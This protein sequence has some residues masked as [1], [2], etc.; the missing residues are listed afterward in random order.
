M[1]AIRP[2][3]ERFW[4]KVDKNGVNGCWLWQA[5]KNGAGYGM[6]GL[7]GHAGAKVLAH[8]FSYV[9]LHGPITERLE[10]D[11]LCR[12]T[13]CV[14]PDHLEAVTHQENIMRG[15]KPQLSKTHCPKG[16]PYDLLN[17]YFS[18]SGRRE[19]RICRATQQWVRRH[20][21]D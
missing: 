17:T 9:L 6:I 4:E 20:G 1:P 2:I 11:H 19:C 3:E 18:P 8:R 5:G 16:H 13:L 10:I 14:N 7:S 12:N 21:N 15:S